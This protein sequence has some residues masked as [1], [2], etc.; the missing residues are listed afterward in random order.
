[1]KPESVLLAAIALLCALMALVLT[2]GCAVHVGEA[3]CRAY[4]RAVEGRLL[5]CGYLED[6]WYRLQLAKIYEQC[7]AGPLGITLVDS[8][9]ASD[10]VDEVRAESCERLER[11][12]PSCI[13]QVQL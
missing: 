11:G 7:D 1:M 8:D 10:C 2:C 6:E 12:A 4:A 5:A 9:D 13:W 3:P